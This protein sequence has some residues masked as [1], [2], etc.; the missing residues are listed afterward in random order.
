MQ[1]CKMGIWPSMAN[2]LADS[3]SAWFGCPHLQ[4][5]SLR[6]PFKYLCQP[7]WVWCPRGVMG[8]GYRGENVGCHQHPKFDPKALL[9][10]V[11]SLSFLV[12]LAL[13]LSGFHCLCSSIICKYIYIYIYIYTHIY[14]CI[15]PSIFIHT[16]IRIYISMYVYICIYVYMY[17]YIDTYIYICLHIFIYIYINKY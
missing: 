15:Y 8:P 11:C 14:A 1:L 2:D 12:I 4:H 3:A 17:T 6:M 7:P 16:C 13:P 10:L 9:I 5:F